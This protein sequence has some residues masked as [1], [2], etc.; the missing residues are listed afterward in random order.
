L[1]TDQKKK[2]NKNPVFANARQIYLY[3]KD[4]GYQVA[5][6]TVYNHIEKGLLQPK[7]GGGF[8][9]R[10]VDSYALSHLTK[11]SPDIEDDCNFAPSPDF[12]DLQGAG[13]RKQ[14]NHADYLEYQAKLKQLQYKR[15]SGQVIPK[16]M[17][18]REMAAR[19]QA[20]RFGLESFGHDVA[21]DLAGIFGGEQA[22]AE[23]MLR[24]LDI[25]LD[26]APA[27]AKWIQGRI[28][29]VLAIWEDKIEEFL[30]PYA[31]ETEAWWTDD[32][33]DY[34]REIERQQE[35]QNAGDSS[36]HSTF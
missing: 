24:E 18:E 31:S 20:F 12:E 27:V 13:E 9:Q 36:Q 22:V 29:Q 2:E 16:D 19:A 8:S 5:Q 15:E 32:M 3:L 26:L 17:V 33:A 4:Q 6:Q 35:E 23:K 34:M 11:V 7:R 25:S 21:P 10:T 1:S 14:K 30:E 28:P